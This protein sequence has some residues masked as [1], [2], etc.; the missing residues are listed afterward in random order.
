M[1]GLNELDN[2]EFPQIG[3]YPNAADNATGIPQQKSLQSWNSLLSFIFDRPPPLHSDL[4]SVA[5]FINSHQMRLALFEKHR[6]M[7][8][9]P[10]KGLLPLVLPRASWSPHLSHKLPP[11]VCSSILTQQALPPSCFSIQV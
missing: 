5:L 8:V 11:I 9:T 6:E 3:K 10:L 7:P 4:M 2:K 1:R